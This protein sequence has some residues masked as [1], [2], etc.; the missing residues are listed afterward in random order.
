MKKLGGILWNVPDEREQCFHFLGGLAPYASG[1]QC[2]MPKRF[3]DL[4]D[5]VLQ[6]QEPKEP[7][8]VF[9][10]TVWENAGRPRKTITTINEERSS[11]NVNSKAFQMFPPGF[12]SAIESKY[13]KEGRQ[14]NFK[15]VWDVVDLVA[16][17]NPTKE[18]YTFLVSSVTN[19]YTF[20]FRKLS[21][22]K[23]CYEFILNAALWT[24]FNNMSSR[25][26]A[27]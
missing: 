5:A 12:K 2:L 26:Q 9:A 23:K 6:N 7:L 11:G 27:S 4:R 20:G 18:G 17:K 15:A 24:Q 25:S 8:E 3:R 19:N 22:A 21:D 16:L 1:L 14:G 13:E 10:H